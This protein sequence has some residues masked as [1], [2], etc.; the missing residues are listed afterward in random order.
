M[1]AL[2]RIIKG[3]TDKIVYV[4]DVIFMAGVEK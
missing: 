4:W 3:T 2:N 1:K